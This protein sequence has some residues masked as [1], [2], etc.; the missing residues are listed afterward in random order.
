MKVKKLNLLA[1]FT[2]LALIIFAAESMIPPLVPVP[3]IK[4]GLSNIITLVILRN[5]TAKD[6]ALVLFMRIVLASFFFGQALSLLY[7]LAGGL[8]CLIAM[9]LMNRLFL[10]H[11]LF[12]TSIAGALSHNAGQ[13]LTA[14]FI[15]QTAGIFI[16]LPFLMLGGLI[17][18]LFIGL[19]AHFSQKYLVPL[20]NR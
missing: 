15:T 11:Y 16:Y 18:G 8:L 13:L 1:L 2:T 19:C 5:F 10:G 14:F 4:L 17:T 12:L 3:G 9:Y 20:I 6:A 7:S